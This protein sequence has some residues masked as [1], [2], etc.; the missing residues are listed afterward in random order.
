MEHILL[1]GL[2]ITTR[3][4]YVRISHAPT[5]S[6]TE[7]VGA[8]AMDITVPEG[9]R[10]GDIVSRY[11]EVV[12]DLELK[13]TDGYVLVKTPT[14]D[15]NG[16]VLKKIAPGII[17]YN[18]FLV[19]DIT[20]F[21]VWYDDRRVVVLVPECK[22]QDKC[23]YVEAVHSVPMFEIV[24]SDEL[25]SPTNIYGLKMGDENFVFD[26]NNG[27]VFAT[28]QFYER[29]S[30]RMI[31]VMHSFITK[32]GKRME[33][34]GLQLVGFQMDEE[35]LSPNN[36][37]YRI[38]ELGRQ[39]SRP[40]FSVSERYAVKHKSVIEFELSAS[41]LVVCNDFKTRYQNY[42]LVSDFTEF[43]TTDSHGVN[44]MSNV[45][46]GEI[47]TNYTQDFE[48]DQVGAIASTAQFSCEL[49]YYVVFDDTY[50]RI[51]K[52]IMDIT[53]GNMSVGRTIIR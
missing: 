30:L 2:R 11:I 28:K 47:T 17:S 45:I 29:Y 10:G 7:D 44:W 13:P 8:S 22:I 52:I 3:C 14:V 35:S 5:V 46:W 23:T 37:K 21:V 39:I 12:D 41:S 33:D 48:T 9:F 36:V 24:S 53:D 34:Y 42:D 40:S 49:N 18:Q 50:P 27:F 31:D 32:L 16:L 43:Y 1:Q 51:K 6:V 38:T 15:L 25:Q 4:K 19:K 26:S 20:D